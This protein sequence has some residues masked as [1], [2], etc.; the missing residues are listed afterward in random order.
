MLNYYEK[1]KE[2]YDSG[3]Q[4]EDFDSYRIW[5]SNVLA[6]LVACGKKELYDAF[7]RFQNEYLPMN[8]FHIFI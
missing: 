1:I 5:N 8:T 7:Y 2:F 4:I 6:Y 3:Q